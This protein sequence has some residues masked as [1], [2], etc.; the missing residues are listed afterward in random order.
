MGMRV[1][2]PPDQERLAAFLCILASALLVFGAKVWLIRDVGSIT[3]FWDQWDGEGGAL[4]EPYLTGSL[5]W[6]HL[7]SAHN[8]HRI[9]FPRLLHLLLLELAGQWDPI[10]QMLVN[11]VLHV[12]FIV[13]LVL[14]LGKLVPKFAYFSLCLFASALVAVPLSWEN[15]L[16]GFQS[17]FYF[18]LIF[19]T[20]ALV[21]LI[22]AAP[23]RTRWWAG[24][25]IALS[26][27][28]CLSSGALTLVPVI[29]LRCVQLAV[30]VRS[31]WREWTG[32][33]VHVLVTI[34][35]IMTVPTV[36]THSE[37]KAH[38]VGQF[39]IALWTIAGWPAPLHWW[40]AALVYLPL[41]ILF[42]IACVRRSAVADPVWMG[43]AVGLWVAVQ[44]A[45]IAYGRAIF[46]TSSR[47]LDLALVG[48]IVNFAAACRFAGQR[49]AKKTYD[50]V[51]SA[52]T[53]LWLFLIAY[54]LINTATFRL[55]I[56]IPDKKETN[57]F[58]TEN[59]R[60]FLKTDDPAVLTNQPF[61]HI[62][63][64]LPERLIALLRNDAIRSTLPKDLIGESP[65]EHDAHAKLLLKGSLARYV[66]TF[67]ASLLKAPMLLLALSFAL[68]GFAVPALATSARSIDSTADVP[69]RSGALA[70]SISYNRRNAIVRAY[71]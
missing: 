65:G 29:A 17:P 2:R 46:V 68:F 22:P 9:F 13:T 31:G 70:G 35:V 15:T 24:T 58:Q 6:S 25:G 37:F 39:L 62:P 26:S 3:P 52:L 42:G 27:A 55:P 8:E 10:L 40:S 30:R 32:I 48:L 28:L 71:E 61:L 56:E 19:A 59:V 64:P 66:S 67:K 63:Y 43:L 41:L 33:A 57:R 45:S 44:L 20:G 38:S 11:A 12:V 14:V 47:Y 18:L 60:A 7:L 54:F 5:T 36:A 50:L 49:P 21:L 1:F 16:G 34:A 53:W 23:L 51:P 4:Y 69:D